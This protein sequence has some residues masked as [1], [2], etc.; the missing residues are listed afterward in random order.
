VVE[1]ACKNT[2][3]TSWC[4][5]FPPE[6]H[7]NGKSVDGTNEFLRDLSTHHRNLIHIQPKGLWENK[8]VQVNQAINAVKKL[9][10][11]CFLWEIDAD[12]QWTKEQIEKSE[13]VL[14]E[15]E[16]KTGCF[17]CNY[18]VGKNLLAK[19]AWGEGYILPY[20]RLW[21]WQGER[22]E[23]HEPPRL[24]NGNG[25][26]ILIPIRFNH[27]ALFFE[28]DVLFKKAWYNGYEMLDQRWKALQ[29]AT[30][31]PRPISDLLGTDLHWGRTNTT[32]VKI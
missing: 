13:V 4:K 28:K 29:E 11:Q 20:R 24:E 16:A 17:L 23:T 8:D 2:G 15:Q 30:S 14:M 6:F 32:I 31:F 26:G 25:M 3:S 7:N 27:Y 5:P 18:F 12:E 19:G 9:T 10:N 1:G 22:F 21:Y